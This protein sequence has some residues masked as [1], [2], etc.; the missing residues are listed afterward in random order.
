MRSGDIV[1]TGRR[2]K[3]SV[4]MITNA[5][6]RVLDASTA[7]RTADGWTYGFPEMTPTQ[8]DKFAMRVSSATPDAIPPA[9]CADPSADRRRYFAAGTRHHH[10]GS[11]GFIQVRQ[12]S[13]RAVRK[14][15][16]RG[17]GRGAFS[18]Y[19]LS[20]STNIC[21]NCASMADYRKTRFS[22][23]PTAAHCIA[24]CLSKSPCACAA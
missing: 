15:E 23:R 21:L 16:T 6:V 13:H 7:F 10:H 24:A 22:C 12:G 9:R 8:A 11:V 20:K 17:K 19:G 5:K 4:G 3:E 2:C 14:S 1:F 18:L